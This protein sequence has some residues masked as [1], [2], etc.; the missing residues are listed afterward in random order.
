MAIVRGVDGCPAGWLSL[1]LDA[2]DGT[3]TPQVFGDTASLLC[4]PG[5]LTAIDIPIG[6]ASSGVR[7][8]DEEARLLLGPRRSS[9]FS[10]PVRAA[11]A[12]DTYKTACEAS[13]LACGKALSQQSYALLPKIRDVDDELQRVHGLSIAV[14]EVHPEVSFYFWN[15][16]RPMQYPKKTGFGFMERF[17]LVDRLWGGAATAVRN[18]VPRAEASD[19]DILDAFA[20][21]WTARRIHAG[22]ATRL[23][24]EKEIDEFGLPMHMWA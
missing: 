12:A 24:A 11:L 16:N 23:P 9:V 1:S 8:C 22:T 5:D 20:A 6:L 3:P 15:G 2:E 7:R 19:D 4:Q 14:R 21:L 10:A 17:R 18:T 13:R